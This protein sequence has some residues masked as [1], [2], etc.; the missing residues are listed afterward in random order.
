MYLSIFTLLCYVVY[1]ISTNTNN[2]LR[3]IYINDKITSNQTRKNNAYKNILEKIKTQHQQ[4]PNNEKLLN[5]IKLF[6]MYRDG[7]PDQYDSDGNKL[8]GIAPNAHRAIHHIRQG[9]N[10]GWGNWGLFELAKLLHY[11]IVNFDPDLEKARQLYMHII[12]RTKDAR[13]T[14]ESQ[15]K[16]KEICFT[17]NQLKVFRWLNISPP[18]EKPSQ[19][20][21]NSTSTDDNLHVTSHT[22]EELH[23]DKKQPVDVKGIINV[24]ENI[25]LNPIVTNN[26]ENDANDAN[27]T[28]KVKNDMQNVHDSTLLSTIR[29]SLKKLQKEIN[30]EKLLPH[31][32]TLAQIRQYI[33]S[34]GK[35][36][37]RNDAIQALNAIERNTVPLS[38]TQL[39]EVDALQ[40]VWSR[41]ADN[42]DDDT[43]TQLKENLY[44]ELAEC[45]EHDKPV[46][47]T[48]RF[49]RIVDTLNVID[50]LV[51][52]KP[53]FA[54]Q[55]EMMNKCSKIRENIF[56][57]QSSKHQTIIDSDLEGKSDIYKQFDAKLKCKIRKVL[58]KD[59]V[60][61][62]IWKK[63]KLEK[64]INK[65]IDFI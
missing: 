50:P 34:Q 60:S 42:K 17:I 65:W 57:K 10:N 32:K 5:H 61:S 44:S 51:E 35:N 40:L 41:I 12:L 2:P 58:H 55:Q 1:S 46:C 52:I 8:K 45:I 7:V 16:Y 9:I 53:T 59:Y 21:N 48:G 15:Q 62:G 36:D 26:I 28:K 6:K 49:T 29:L 23:I 19:Q 56:N 20:F 3:K 30:G 47:S 37:K 54:I 63:E 24:T 31:H 25:D 38:S 39:K 22:L 64:E 18:L 43:K 13:L 4:Q 27:G 14:S 33:R 11:G